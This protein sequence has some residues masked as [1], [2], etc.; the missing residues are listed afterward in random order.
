MI[1]K[2]K[3]GWGINVTTNDLFSNFYSPPA[4]NSENIIQTDQWQAPQ[5]YTVTLELS[6][7]VMEILNWA[8]NKMTEE[9]ELQ[10]L[11]SKFPILEDAIR[12]LEVIK[13]LIKGNKS[14]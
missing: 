14:Q 4:S 7:D 2:I 10:E 1:G 5:H 13:A 8:Q 6:S 12:D 11:A 3:S 9:L